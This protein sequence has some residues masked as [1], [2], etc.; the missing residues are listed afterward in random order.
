METGTTQLKLRLPP[1]T[2]DLSV[3]PPRPDAYGFILLFPRILLLHGR[4]RLAGADRQAAP[5]G[6]Q[7]T[8]RTPVTLQ[9]LHGAASLLRRQTPLRR[10]NK[11]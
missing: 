5:G 11:T 6:H 2:A 4:E 3:L 10:T 8:L 1:H 7:K 9:P